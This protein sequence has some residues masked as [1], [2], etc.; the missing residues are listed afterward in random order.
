MN[1]MDADPSSPDYEQKREA[2]RLHEERIT[3][4]AAK[5]E[6]MVPAM[7][8][9]LDAFEEGATAESQN[10]SSKGGLEEMKK[11][12]LEAQKRKE[13]MKGQEEEVEKDENGR[14]RIKR[15][16]NCNFLASVF[17]NVTVVSSRKDRRAG[18]KRSRGTGVE[19]G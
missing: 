1:G 18:G 6:E 2:A 11:R 13:E 15:K 7:T 12:A 9:L 17:A 8:R 14:P 4:Q 19:I 5:Q 16:S 3:K 10:S